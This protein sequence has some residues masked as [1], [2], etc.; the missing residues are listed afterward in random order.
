MVHLFWGNSQF[1]TAIEF[2]CETLWDL[3]PTP[4]IP[5]ELG[6]LRI[7]WLL[8][9]KTTYFWVVSWSCWYSM[10]YRFDDLI[11]VKYIKHALNI[12]KQTYHVFTCKTES[13]RL[14]SAI[15]PQGEFCATRAARKKACKSCKKR[16]PTGMLWKLSVILL[17]KSWIYVNDCWWKNNTTW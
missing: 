9:L 17:Q 10:F 7:H 1:K 8:Q 6:I 15:H 5:A 13:K 2:S 4:K 3:S 16:S 11:G 14:K 12:L